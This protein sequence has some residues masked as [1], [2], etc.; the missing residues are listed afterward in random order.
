M[1]SRTTSFES[2]LRIRARPVALL[3]GI[4]G[5]ALLVASSLLIRSAEQLRYGYLA[6]AISICSSLIWLVDGWQPLP[7]RWCLLVGLFGL[8]YTLGRWLQLPGALAL[9]GLSPALAASLIGFSAAVTVAVGETLV[10]FALMAYAP[11]GLGWAG[12]A[13][14][15]IGIYATL[16]AVYALYRP[17][18]QLSVWLS[19]YFDR[20]Q[21]LVEEARD[22]RAA[23]EEALDSLANANRQLVLAN[24]RMGA[25]RTIAEEAQRAKT[26]FVA[27]VSHEFR[28][29]LNMIVGLVDIM[30]ENPELYAVTLSPR[31]REDLAVVHRNCQYLSHLINDVLDLTRVEAGRLALHRERTNLGEVVQRAVAAVE[32]L[33]TK[34]GLTIT[35]E[36][37]ADLPPVYCDRTRIQQVVLNLVS[38]AARFT[39]DGGIRIEVTQQAQQVCVRVADTGPG[40]AAGDVERVFEPFY[41]SGGEL[42][43]DK[44]G[45]GLGLSISRQFVGLHGGRMWIESQL[46]A[47]TSVFFTLP[48]SP[49]IEH[50]VRPGHQIRE[51]WVWRETAFRVGGV[52]ATE[53]VAKPRVIVCDETGGIHPGFA[54]YGEQVELVD[55][56]EVA[57]ALAALR[58]SPVRAVVVNAPAADELWPL[59]EVVR[60]EAP[61]TA[62][63]GCS[64][65]QAGKRALD[66]GAQGHLT[67]PVTRAKLSAII[68]SIGRPVKRV[69][70]VDDDVDVLQLFSSMLLI[71]DPALEV[72]TVSSGK[73]ALAALRRAPVDLVLL[74]IVMPA[75]DGWEVLEA[76]RSEDEMRDI[77]VFF[78]SAQD[79]ADEPPAT[80]FL[81]ATTAE[82]LSLS[83]LLRCALEIGELLLKPEAELHPAPG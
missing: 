21:T 49:P 35:V 70:V 24:E 62:V 54:R 55:T 40:I 80:D 31:M 5:L 56:R 1:V 38:N 19:Q 57:Q 58:Q 82:G 6:L 41:Q 60:G 15:L 16:G 37:P 33:V 22:R 72:L 52:T 66:A 30:M 12:F 20:A 26:A 3:F 44:G 81:L 14:G 43:R 69:L 65:P 36:I 48:I 76:V 10:L 73:E 77:P 23:L 27:N 11:A 53:E 8:V 78:V 18:H 13:A 2:E 46:G 83:R 64:V 61:S 47:G 74:D 17:V 67:K 75:M 34:K 50:G 68:K 39:D 63:I 9:A 79:P 42:W 29:P 7:A 4:L 32:P 51:D 59:I 71:C 45:S 28:T 25:L